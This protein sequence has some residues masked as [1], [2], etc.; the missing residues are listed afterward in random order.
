MSSTP[1]APAP[2][3]VVVTVSADG[4]YVVSGPIEIRTADGALA[5]AVSKAALCRC[6]HSQ[7]KPFCDGSHRDAGFSDPGPAPAQG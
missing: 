4:P 3:P 5:K 2:Q 1:E 7:N 6:G